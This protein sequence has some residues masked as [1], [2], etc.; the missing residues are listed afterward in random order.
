MERD[1]RYTPEKIEIK[2]MPTKELLEA[3]LD[4]HSGPVTVIFNRNTGKFERLD[5]VEIVYTD[6]GPLGLLKEEKND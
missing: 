1:R 4:G 6:C 5:N 3:Y 2:E